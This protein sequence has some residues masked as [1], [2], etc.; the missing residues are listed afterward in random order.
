MTALA[1]QPLRYLIARDSDAGVTGMVTVIGYGADSLPVGGAGYINCRVENGGRRD[2]ILY[3][4]PPDDIE[5]EYGE[6]AIVFTTLSFWDN[7]DPQVAKWKRLGAPAVEIDNLD[8]YDVAA[9]LKMF[10]QVAKASIGVLVKNAAIVDGDQKA[11]LAHPAAA[12]VI[13]EQDCGTP[14]AYEALRRAAG[15]PDMPIRFVAYGEGRPWAQQVAQQIKAAGYTDMAVTYSPDGEYGSVEHILLPTAS[16]SHASDDMAYSLTWL[17]DVLRAAGLKVVETEGWKSRGRGDMGSVKG[18][19]CHHTG[20][21]R[22][23][24]NMPTL[25]VLIEGRSDLAGPLSQLGLGYD[26]TYYC[27]GAG[28]CNHAGPGGWR[29]LSGNGNVIGIEAENPGDG[30]WP[31]VQVEAYIRGVAAICKHLGIS[32]SM[33]CGHKEWTS[34]K[35]DPAGIDMGDFRQKVQQLLDGGSIQPLPDTP[36]NRP[37]LGKGDSGTWVETLQKLIGVKVDGDFGPDTD[38]AVRAYQATRGLKV[39]GLV[40]PNTWG[41]LMANAPA[42]QPAPTASGKASWYG[43]YDGKYRWRDSGDAP[44]S[45]ALGVPDDAQGVS[46]PQAN[47][48]IG[49]WFA[50]TGPEGLTTIE[51]QTEHGPAAWTGK[52]I[53][54]HAACAERHGYSPHNIP[55]SPNPF[56]TPSIWSWRK[57]PAPAAVAGLSPQQQAVKWRD[58]RASASAEPQEPSNPPSEGNEPPVVVPRASE[59][60]S[61]EQAI[62]RV[63]AE[64]DATQSALNTLKESIRMAQQPAQ[65]QIDLTAIVNLVQQLPQIIAAI[66]QIVTVMQTLGPILSIFG[67][68]LPSVTAVPDQPKTSGV[69]GATV[70]AAGAGVG[71]GGLI[72]AV[73]TALLSGK[74]PQ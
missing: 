46:F 51:Q 9:A 73:L 70:G 25:N 45:N 48:T 37:V 13:V 58:L 15:K 39:D 3:I 1:G 60:V 32:S 14:A 49:Q 64:L 40:G 42:I 61:V 54:I 8:T 23:S 36:Q 41:A 12:M 29:G 44:N 6:P 68:K 47:G 17:A 21:P 20:T 30:Q 16:T 27:V 5:R 65:P 67:L 38:A 2:G 18:V 69:S 74:V 22:S 52:S 71:I 7:F 35:D 26:G 4:D 28:L 24:G 11:L 66:Q 72:G 34:R 55:N 33:V 62:D 63:Q 43:Q 59:P 10:D 31:A 19:V 53:D 50:I 56:P 57:V